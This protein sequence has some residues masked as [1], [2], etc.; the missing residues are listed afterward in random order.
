M[1][2]DRWHPSSKKCS[3]CGSVSKDLRL[4]DRS[5]ECYACES[6]H[7][8]DINVAINILDSAVSLTVSAC[9][10]ESSGLVH[11]DRVKASLTKQELNIIA[12]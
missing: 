10:E 6:P 11:G 3:I 7:E 5:W 9:G 8:G 12:A 2:I 1:I 4:S